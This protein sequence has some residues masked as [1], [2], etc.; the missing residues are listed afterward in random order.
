[1][2]VEITLTNSPEKAIIDDYDFD[3]VTRFNWYLDQGQVYTRIM[4]PIEDP[5]ATHKSYALKVRLDRFLLHLT[6]H[7]Y[8][9]IDHAFGPLNNC[10]RWIYQYPN[11]RAERTK[12]MTRYLGVKSKT[13]CIVAEYK[14]GR[15]KEIMEFEISR[16]A[17][18]RERLGKEQQAAEKYDGWARQYE[19][20]EPKTN[21]LPRSIYRQ[22]WS[23]FAALEKSKPHQ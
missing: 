15:N 23:G 19:G 20:W 7:N 13:G 5:D 11:P 2:T 16:N 21:F 12:G 1:M 22:P 9:R 4:V 18:E 6:T 10:R 17:E 8:I 14:K 3:Q